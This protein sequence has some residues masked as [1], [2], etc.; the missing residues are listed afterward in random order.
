V[1]EPV[2]FYS[3]FESLLFALGQLST[4]TEAKFPLR[5]ADAICL[6]CGPAS[7]NQRAPQV[8]PVCGQ[9]W[10]PLPW[11]LSAG[12]DRSRVRNGHKL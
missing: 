9:G 2:W 10:R 6:E 7:G 11:T 4:M 1:V 8:L 12:R 3:T 5:D